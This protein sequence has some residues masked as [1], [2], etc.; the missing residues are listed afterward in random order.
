MI[1]IK[2]HLEYL[3]K[4]G[5]AVLAD[6]TQD[7]KDTCTSEEAIAGQGGYC[8]ATHVVLDTYI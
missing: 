3:N 6:A 8:R 2:W 4:S 1:P 5:T 7:L